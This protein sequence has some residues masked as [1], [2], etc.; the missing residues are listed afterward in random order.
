MIAG[1]GPVRPLDPVLGANASAR[2]VDRLATASRDAPGTWA[3]S[4]ATPEAIRPG[5]TMPQRTV[6]CVQ[7]LVPFSLPVMMDSPMGISSTYQ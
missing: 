1:I 5:P 4:L 6:S 3:K 2:S 7:W